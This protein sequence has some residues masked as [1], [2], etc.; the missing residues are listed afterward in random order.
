M[1]PDGARIVLPAAAEPAVLIVHR[2]REAGHEALLAGGCVRDLLLELAPKDYDVATAAHPQVVMSLFPATRQVGA[3]FGVVLVRSRRV[4]VEV[5]TFRSDL[6]YRDGR[7]PSGVRFTDAEHDARRRDFTINGMFLDPMKGAVL[8]FVGGQRD[9]EARCVRAIGEPAQRFAE[10]LLRLL[11][12][13]RI[14]SRLDFEI[15]ARTLAAIR[16]LAS[17]LCDVAAERVRE[18]LE[19]MLAH[20]GRARALQGLESTGLLSYLWAG[21]AWSDA[22]LAR[23]R[24]WLA[25]LAPQASFV[26]ALSCLLAEKTGAELERIS[27]R[28]TLSN[29][30]REGLQWVVGQIRHWTDPERPSLADLKQCLA[31][32]AF[33]DLH[34]VLSA[35]YL[36][37][38]GATGRREILA[39]RVAGVAADAIRPAPLISGEDLL[40]R[41]LP[42]GPLFKQ[43]LDELYTRQ[44]NEE[45]GSRE[46]ALS[47][48]DRLLAVRAD[49]R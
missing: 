27:R 9:L 18:E 19:K 7:R 35:M 15:E 13:V 47:V 44:L 16:D 12:A 41:R 37:E 39:N 24:P 33:E 21:A 30:Q 2:L 31:S 5:A 25:C 6:E 20:A 4:W 40:A 45:F 36:A 28:L 14:A 1:S 8:D 22:E 23:A 38:P 34:A 11:R 17:R 48:L 29:E 49:D 46:A 10:D 32:P 3:Q 26:A 42:Q 43:L